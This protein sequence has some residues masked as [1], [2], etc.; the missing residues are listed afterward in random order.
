MKFHNVRECHL[1]SATWRFDNPD[2]IAAMRRKA[3]AH[4]PEIERRQLILQRFTERVR[5]HDHYFG[6][7]LLPEQLVIGMCLYY[8]RKDV[9]SRGDA[10]KGLTTTIRRISQRFISWCHH[11]IFVPSWFIFVLDRPYPA[12]RAYEKKTLLSHV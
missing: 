11:R 6:G 9:S 2:V 8:C 4:H 7:A 5:F 12:V 3:E 1:V 10:S